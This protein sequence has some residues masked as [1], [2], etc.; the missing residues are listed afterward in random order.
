MFKVR[1]WSTKTSELNTVEAV[2]KNKYGEEKYK[3]SGKYTEK[4][5][6]LDLETGKSWT[7]F[8][9]PQKPQNYL[10]MFGYNNYALQLNLLSDSLAKK[11]PPTDTRFRPDVRFWEQADLD[12]A[13]SEK[14]RLEENQRERRKQIKELFKNQKDVDVGDERTFY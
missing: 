3:I 9:A 1:G 13:S 14:T 4:L 12:T 10:K 8:T 2:I 6:A 11:L 7:V 5:T